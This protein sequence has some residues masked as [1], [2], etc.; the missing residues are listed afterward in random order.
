MEKKSIALFLS[1]L[2]LFPALVFGD[3][4]NLGYFNNFFVPEDD[5]IIFYAGAQPIAEVTLQDC[6]VDAQSTVRL[7]SGMVCDGDH[8]LI[9]GALCTIMTVKLPY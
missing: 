1:F 9:D 3:C 5:T 2:F 4:A 8:I 7:L 6:T